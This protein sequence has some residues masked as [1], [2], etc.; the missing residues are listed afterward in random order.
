MTRRMEGRESYRASHG[1]YPH[2]RGHWV[3]EMMTAYG[4]R[5]FEHTGMY[6][7]ACR[8]AKRAAR[9]MMASSVRVM[10]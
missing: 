9:E 8:A 1:T 3:F 5:T 10:S 2:G 6:S 7:E 4:V